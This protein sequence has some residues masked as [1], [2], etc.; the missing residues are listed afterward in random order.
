VTRRPVPLALG[1]ALVLAGACGHKA[2]ILGAGRGDAIVY[3]DANVRDAGMWIDG[4]FIGG[5]DALRGGVALD[6]GEHRVE[7]R[8]DDYFGYYAE[9]ALHAGERKRIKVE[10]AP[11]LP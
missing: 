10:L 2:P 7:I 9:L 1:L 3:I 4:M 8:H 5:L 6:P 11:V